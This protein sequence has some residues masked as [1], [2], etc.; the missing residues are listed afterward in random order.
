MK[1]SAAFALFND[2]VLAVQVAFIP[3]LRDVYNQPSMIFH[4]SHTFMAHVWTAF[5]A[6]TDENGR[7]VKSALLREARGT[8]LDLGAGFGHTIQYL[9][10]S[11]VTRYIAL[12]P[13]TRMHPRLHQ[14]AEAAGY[15]SSDGSLVV[16][17]CGAE[18]VT[19][20]LKD[21][22]S[23]YPVSTITSVLTLCSIPSP[24]R[25]LSALV[26]DVLEP[27]GQVLFYEHVL[28]PRADVAWW[29]R[30]WT[31]LWSIFLD[32]CRLDCPTHL[33]ISEMQYRSDSG[34]SLRMWDE[35]ETWGKPGEAEE[36][37]WW[38]QAGRFVKHPE[39]AFNV[40]IN[41]QML[42][43]LI[44]PARPPATPTS[45]HAD[46]RPLLDLPLF[47]L[48]LLHARRFDDARFTFFD[49]GL[50]AC[51]TTNV[52]SDFVVALN[53]AQ[54]GGGEDCYQTI[55]ISYNGMSTQAQI[56]DECPGCPYGG[57][58]LSTG[59]FQ[60]FAPEEVGVL[61]GSWDFG[62]SKEP[63]SGTPPAPT[64]TQE[65]SPTSASISSTF[66]PSPSLPTTTTTTA[67]SIT[68]VAPSSA[69]SAIASS[70]VL[71]MF[72]QT[73]MQLAIIS[74]DASTG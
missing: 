65:P 29:Q 37:L 17:S 61:Y 28:S 11:K 25:V 6:P 14:T 52:P 53:S 71:G 45:T 39:R 57:L 59:L 31:P 16:L 47:C 44:M 55:T 43:I 22:G 58:D 63:S 72:E 21:L 20:I 35:G 26:R 18:D 51:G 1:L 24:D 74:A 49:V 13:N 8:V 70:G 48:L 30:F 33:Y 32:G 56:V 19:Q 54:Y 2:L 34:K 5:A 41:Y 9:D 73:V 46:P 62:G 7:E 40:F 4:I 3:T 23:P 12:E 15:H 66:A 27:G 36:N 67:V 64:S 38:H 42:P 68:S 69:P 10:R 60:Y 50:G